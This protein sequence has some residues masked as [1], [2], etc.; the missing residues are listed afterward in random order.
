MTYDEL[1]D[2]YIRLR[3]KMFA[4]PPPPKPP[5]ARLGQSWTTKE[6]RQT[7][8]AMDRVVQ[9]AALLATGDFYREIDRRLNEQNE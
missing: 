4:M 5:Y 3:N 9:Q 7:I 6:M 8:A 1:V 2:E